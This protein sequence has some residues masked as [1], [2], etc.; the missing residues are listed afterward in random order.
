MNWYYNVVVGCIPCF[1]GD[2]FQIEKRMEK[3]KWRGENNGILIRL[4]SG[5]YGESSIEY[6]EDEVVDWAVKVA[7]GHW[8]Q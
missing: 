4:N 5:P 7:G 1:S 2:A 8:I 6:D 3:T